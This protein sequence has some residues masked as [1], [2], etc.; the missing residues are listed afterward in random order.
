MRSPSS[1]AHLVVAVPI[2]VVVT[3]ASM[4]MMALVAVTVSMPNLTLLM[5]LPVSIGVT[6]R[7][8]PGPVPFNMAVERVHERFM[9]AVVSLHVDDPK[10]VS[11]VLLDRQ[12][13]VGAPLV[14]AQNDRDSLRRTVSLVCERGR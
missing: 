4:G 2:V 3:M 8:M 11:V 14:L 6:L 10:P 9:I 12:L 1:F 13:T 5:M 7:H